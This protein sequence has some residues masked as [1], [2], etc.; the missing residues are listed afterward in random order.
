MKGN[1]RWAKGPSRCD[2]CYDMADVFCTRRT[3]MCC[4]C[5]L[6]ILGCLTISFINIIQPP[7]DAKDEL[8]LSFTKKFPDAKVQR[9]F[10]LTQQK[11]IERDLEWQH[12][13]VNNP[14]IVCTIHFYSFIYQ[15]NFVFWMFYSIFRILC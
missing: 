15:N 9:D 11:L 3:M 7:W 5:F 8:G 6:I 2:V 1:P 14:I 13:L 12:A 4:L 10:D